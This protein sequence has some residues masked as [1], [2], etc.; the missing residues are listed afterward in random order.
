MT[1]NCQ[2]VFDVYAPKKDF[3][4]VGI[5]S[6]GELNVARTDA[7]PSQALHSFPALDPTMSALH[8]SDRSIAL[9]DSGV[10]RSLALLDPFGA[11]M[12]GGCEEGDD[13]DSCAKSLHVFVDAHNDEDRTWRR[14]ASAPSGMAYSL[15]SDRR[16]PGCDSSTEERGS[17]R[18]A[19][20]TPLDAFS[21]SSLISS[22]LYEPVNDLHGSCHWD[23]GALSCAKVTANSPKEPPLVIQKD[24]LSQR[25][26]HGLRDLRTD[27]RP[28]RADAAGLGQKPRPA[29]AGRVSFLLPPGLSDWKVPDRH[30]DKDKMRNLQQ[31]HKAPRGRPEPRP[32][33][34][35]HTAE[36]LSTTA[37]GLPSSLQTRI[38]PS[39]G[40]RASMGALVTS[41]SSPLVRAA[42]PSRRRR[43]VRF[44]PPEPTTLRPGW[45]ATP[46]LPLASSTVRRESRFGRPSSSSHGP[47]V[48]PPRAG[49][50]GDGCG[51]TEEESDI[52]VDKAPKRPQRRNSF[53]SA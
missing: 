30:P 53:D 5:L 39:N 42:S 6:C 17:R 7:V 52:A 2:Q 32:A 43:S 41:S 4:F 28:R 1:P 13:D 46:T 25:L 9:D 31:R 14:S 24:K 37:T 8:E 51:G 15:S 40:R 50:T 36:Q 19:T 20:N 49:G 12:D 3:A 23:A 29:P 47:A 33:G 26:L 34:P 38:M 48:A 16:Y 35:L 10:V 18:E 27:R 44:S 21:Q 11:M 22:L 45:D